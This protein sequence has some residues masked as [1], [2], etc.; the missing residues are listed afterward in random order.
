M[1]LGI[2]DEKQAL[3]AGSVL[4]ARIVVLKQAERGACAWDGIRN[5]STPAASVANAIDPV[6]AGDAFNAGFLSAWLRSKTLDEA[7][8]LGAR[9]G[10]AT[11]AT[12]GDYL[13]QGLAEV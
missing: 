11:V 3:G 4:G 8:H 13:P 9:L 12:L 10:G 2:D 7:L 1:L 6:G 5:A